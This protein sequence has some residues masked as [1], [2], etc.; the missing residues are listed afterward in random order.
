MIAL[1]KV[2]HPET[3]YKDIVEIVSERA[4]NAIRNRS[5]CGPEKWVSGATLALVTNKDN[6]NKRYYHKQIAT[7]NKKKTKKKKMEKPCKAS[8]RVLH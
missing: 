8:A 7:T 4:Q 1:P 5:K 6:T 3:T 2:D